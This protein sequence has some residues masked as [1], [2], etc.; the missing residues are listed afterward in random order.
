MLEPW[1]NPAIPLECGSGMRNSF[2]NT[3][4]RLKARGSSRSQYLGTFL[5]AAGRITKLPTALHLRRTQP[6]RTQEKRHL[7]HWAKGSET[8]RST[9]AR[10]QQGRRFSEPWT[11]RL[12][13]VIRTERGRK[14]RDCQ[15]MHTRTSG[16]GR[17]ERVAW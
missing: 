8:S 15:I 4:C 5:S 17:N 3:A 1:Q 9:T 16:A 12:D 11:G 6:L 14:K 10:P 13:V 7:F 2:T